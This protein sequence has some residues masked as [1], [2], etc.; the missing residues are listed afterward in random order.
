MAGYALR[1]FIGAIVAFAIVAFILAW[2][3]YYL[4]WTYAARRS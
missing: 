3:F 2:A 4:Y 1:R